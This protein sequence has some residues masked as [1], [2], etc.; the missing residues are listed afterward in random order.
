M[1]NVGRNGWVKARSSEGASGY[2]APTTNLDA[3]TRNL[4]NIEDKRANGPAKNARQ[5]T[6]SKY[7]LFESPCFETT[8]FQICIYKQNVFC[9]VIERI[10]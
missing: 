3:S 5:P 10:M 1:K 6:A 9:S 2:N 7:C 4:Q 8:H